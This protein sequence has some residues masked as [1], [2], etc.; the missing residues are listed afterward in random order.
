VRRKGV[1]DTP[2]DIAITPARVFLQFS[3]RALTVASMLE[4][5]NSSKDSSIAL[6]G[7]HPYTVVLTHDIDV[8]SVVG[9]PPGHTLAGFFYRCLVENM[10][11]IVRGHISLRQYGTS[12][13]AALQYLPASVGLGLDAWAK[14]I[15]TMLS[16]ER[17]HG[18][19]ST[20]FFIPL[21]GQP[22]VQ[23]ENGK[24]APGNR[25]A[26]Y[27]LTDYRGL[28][29][30]L[31]LEGWEIGVH[32][33]NAWR[34]VED[35]RCELSVLREA[36][37]E[38]EHFGIRMHWLYKTPGMWKHLDEA[39]YSYDA[40]FGWNDRV[41]FPGGRYVPFESEGAKT[42][43]VLPLNIQDGA[44]LGREHGNL[45]PVD[46][47]QKVEGVLDEAKANGAVVTILWHNNSFVAPRFWGDIYEQILCQAK[48][49][50]AKIST[51]GQ[52]IAE[53]RGR[54]NGKDR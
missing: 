43:M 53:F 40:T 28:L 8:L 33:V 37:P 27:C 47:W 24:P 7:R 10:A 50:G 46:A 26:Y 51:A 19:R 31:A 38:Q 30:D 36:C 20:L 4:T 22:G 32:G 3:I 39:G 13:L 41:G 25:A 15:D 44:L 12:I 6:D 49:D 23:P 16:I 18:V 17:T 5:S 9:L 54:A 45:S 42:L 29:R 14:S 34:S 52:A 1:E 2:T 35:A 48:V 21:Y 11:R